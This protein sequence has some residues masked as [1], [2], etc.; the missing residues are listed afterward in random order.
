MFGIDD[1]EVIA[2]RR[3]V[4]Q[5]RSEIEVRSILLPYLPEGTRGV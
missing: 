4:N 2:R 3:Y 1:T 5:V